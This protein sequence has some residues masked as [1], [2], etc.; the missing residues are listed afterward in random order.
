MP[1]LPETE[2]IA[3]D[4]AELLAGRVIQEVT[5]HRAD[6]LR[7]PLSDRFGERQ[8]GLDVQRVW[9]RA[10]TVVL[11]LSRA[12]HVLVTPRF[13][14]SLQ[15]ETPP[16]PYVVVTWGFRDGSR[17]TYRDV[18]RLGTVTL[19]D[20]EGLDTF[21]RSLGMEPLSPAFTGS[22]LSGILRGREPR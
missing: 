15:F 6:V 1:E 12:H 17:L 13:T 20:D 11:S 14:G 10:K 3:R 2:T 7:G 16:D 5:V 22:T 18:R 19:V 8:V 4:L 9:R 21:D